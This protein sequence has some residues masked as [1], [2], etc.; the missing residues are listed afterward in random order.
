MRLKEEFL[1][2]AKEIIKEGVLTDAQLIEDAAHTM[3]HT[4]LLTYKVPKEL[5]INGKDNKFSFTKRLR[6]KTDGQGQIEDYFYE[7]V[8]V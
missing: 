3:N 8:N 6:P 1:K 5:C 7:G 2:D 4:G